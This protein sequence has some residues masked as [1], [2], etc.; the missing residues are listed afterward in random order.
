MHL[1][2]FQ[3]D[4]KHDLCNDQNPDSPSVVHMG[5]CGLHIMNNA[6]K[7]AAKGSCTVPSSNIQCFQRCSCTCPESSEDLVKSEKKFL[8][9]GVNDTHVTS[10]FI[11]QYVATDIEPFLIEFQSD[12]SVAPIVYRIGKCYI[13]INDY[14][15]KLVQ[16]IDLNKKENLLF[17][18]NIHVGYDTRAALRTRMFGYAP[19]VCSK[20]LET[21]PLKYKLC[22]GV[23]FCDPGVIAKSA[24]L[25]LKHIQ[26]ALEFID[27]E[28]RRLCSKPNVVESVREY[29]CKQEHLL[30]FLDSGS[31]LSIKSALLRICQRPVY[32][33][34]HV[35]RHVYKNDPE[36][37]MLESCMEKLSSRTKRRVS[38]RRLK[39]LSAKRRK[40]IQDSQKKAEAVDKEMC[41]LG[42]V[43][44]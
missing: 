24:N 20:L 42:H 9:E 17:S 35:A 34:G 21:A 40:L 18:N 15:G 29:S 36:H 5:S 3:K 37:E 30:S 6:F 26:M 39:E 8:E 33:G 19:D 22:K 41:V 13:N 38:D 2:K 12:S 23:T 28:F 32:G 31:F 7:T 11:L 27:R 1:L 16:D 44:K 4:L 43:Q 10:A 25:Y 14:C